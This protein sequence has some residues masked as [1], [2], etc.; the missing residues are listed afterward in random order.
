MKDFELYQQILGLVKPWQV[1]QVT[2]Q[3]ES[4]EVEVEVECRESV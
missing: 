1:K 4:G 2:L 3:P